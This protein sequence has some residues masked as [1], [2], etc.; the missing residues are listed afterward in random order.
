MTY[1]KAMSYDSEKWHSTMKSDIDSMYI[2]QVRTMVEDLKV[3]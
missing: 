3:S 2:N 1:T